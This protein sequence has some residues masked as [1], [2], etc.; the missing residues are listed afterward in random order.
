MYVL[1]VLEKL[2]RQGAMRAI[3]EI[4]TARL[5]GNT[6]SR[7]VA[8]SWDQN[9]TEAA[10]RTLVKASELGLTAASPRFT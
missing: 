10:D 9:G 8:E 5:A 6:A 1:D 7:S 2:R 3:E 4:D